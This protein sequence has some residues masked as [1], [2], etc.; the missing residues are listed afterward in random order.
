MRA[1]Q[2]TGAGR[3]LVRAQQAAGNTQGVAPGAATSPGEG[4]RRPGEASLAY[5][6]CWSGA[7]RGSVALGAS[8]Q[9]YTPVSD[10]LQPRSGRKIGF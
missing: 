4:A 1:Q 10:F 8:S 2:A 7:R 6:F 3:A 9:I 5:G